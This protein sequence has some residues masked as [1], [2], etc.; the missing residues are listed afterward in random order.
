[1]VIPILLLCGGLFFWYCMYKCEMAINGCGGFSIWPG[2]WQEIT[3]LV[4]GGRGRYIKKQIQEW[5][6]STSYPN[7]E[8]HYCWS[9]HEPGNAIYIRDNN[10]YNAVGR[11][12]LPGPISFFIRHILIP[13]GPITFY[14]LKG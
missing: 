7:G 4:P 8:N 10:R 11:A 13:F 12:M 2:V 5:E 14:L 9:L 6:K 1:M 3:W